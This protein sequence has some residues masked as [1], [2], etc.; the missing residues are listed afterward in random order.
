MGGVNII[1]IVSSQAAS[2]FT[3]ITL[4]IGAPQSGLTQSGLQHR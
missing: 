2:L 1:S 3:A 4:E